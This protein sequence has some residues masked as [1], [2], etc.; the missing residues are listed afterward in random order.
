MTIGDRC[1]VQ[2]NVSIYK[3]VT[4]ED[5]VFC[6]PSMVFTNVYNPRAFIERKHEFL[7][8]LV[9]RGA[10]IGANST[11]VCG[12][13]IGKYAVIGAGAVVKTDVPDYAIAVGVPAKQKGWACKCGTTLKLNDNHTA[14]LYCGNEYKIENGRLAAIKEK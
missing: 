6:G 14:C 4:L 9:K 2:N 10:T 11:I 13:T 8:T 5:E 12:T 1:K 7:P 3:G